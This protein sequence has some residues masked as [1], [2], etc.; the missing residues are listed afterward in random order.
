ML[1]INEEYINIEGQTLGYAL[2]LVHFSGPDIMF[3]V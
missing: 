1:Y 3:C 2:H